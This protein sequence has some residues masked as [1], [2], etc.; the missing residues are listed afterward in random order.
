VITHS[1]SWVGRGSWALPW[2]SLG[3]AA[4]AVTAYLIF[5][6]APA[7]WVF[8][9]EAIAAGEWWRLLTGYWV[10][11]DARHAGWDIAAL[12]ILGFVF[13]PRLTWRLPL[14][15][16]LASLGVDAWLWWGLPTLGYYCG[17]SAVLN[18]LLVF[19]LVQM[20]RES[21]HPL[22]LLTALAAALKIVVEINTGQSLVTQTV[23]PSVPTT[24]AAGFLCGLLLAAGAAFFDGC[25][26]SARPGRGVHWRAKILSPAAIAGT[27]CGSR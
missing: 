19:G 21:R 4:A 2:L 9:R 13:E 15:L 27:I 14:L 11:S 12:V 6:P 23:W 5:G 10:H 20:W 16:L 3:L 24:H 1:I 26:L 22:V 18:S 17:L 25:G 8:D 7:K